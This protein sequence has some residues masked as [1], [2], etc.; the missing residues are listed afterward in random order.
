MLTIWLF[1]TSSEKIG[2]LFR[3]TDWFPSQSLG[4]EF[5][6]SQFLSPEN[7]LSSILD[8]CTKCVANLERVW[9]G[10]ANGR[11]FAVPNQSVNGKNNLIS[12]WFDKISKRFLC[13]YS[14]NMYNTC[15]RDKFQQKFGWE[16]TLSDVAHQSLPPEIRSHSNALRAIFSESC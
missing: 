9:F 12:G 8:A 5:F 7:I 15:M 16:W 14:F 6:V 3:F 13:V 11:P 1:T 2:W 4:L 10:T